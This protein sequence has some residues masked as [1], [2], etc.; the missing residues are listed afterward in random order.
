MPAE[1]QLLAFVDADD[2]EARGARRRAPRGRRPTAPWPYAF[3]LTMAYS[4]AGAARAASVRTLCA[5][6]V[7][8]D[9]GPE[10]A[11]RASWARRA[12]QHTAYPRGCVAKGQVAT[13][14]SATGPAP[15]PC[16]RR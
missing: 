14:R 10:R 3:A 11:A 5:Q 16:G 6:G 12:W 4:L 13:W 1:P 2:A 9:L 8:V 7:E 15:S